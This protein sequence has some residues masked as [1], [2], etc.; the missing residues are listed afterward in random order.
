MHQHKQDFQ[1]YKNRLKVVREQAA[2]REEAARTQLAADSD[3]DSTGNRG[4][5]DLISETTSIAGSTTTR[6]SHSSRS[7]GR[8]YRSSKNRRKH[9]RKLQSIKEGSVYEDLALI[10]MLHQL[11]TQAYNQRGTI[12]NGK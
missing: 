4:L 6:T 3:D 5:S 7:S 1:K 9:E 11:A 8:T 2:I 10:R 12:F